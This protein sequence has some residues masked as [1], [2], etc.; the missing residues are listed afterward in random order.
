M[1]LRRAIKNTT[2]GVDRCLWSANR[3]LRVE[4]FLDQSSLGG[5]RQ[6]LAG[7]SVLIRTAD[8][9]TTAAALI[10]LDGIASRILICP[11]DVKSEHLSNLAALAGVEAVV[12]TADAPCAVGAKIETVVW[13][14]TPSPA[15]ESET[16][17]LET[18]WLLLTSGTTGAPKIVR[19]SFASLTGLIKPIAESGLPAVWSTFYDIRR[20]GGL[21][22]FLRAIVGGGSLVL[23]DPQ[24][25]VSDFL[26]RLAG[27]GVTHMSGTPSHWRR[28]L[29]NPKIRVFNPSYIRM[30]GEIADQKII[31]NLR[32]AF[33]NA[34]IAHAYASTEAGVVFS[35]NDEL[36]G[37]PVSMIGQSGRATLVKIIDDTLRIKSPFTAADYVGRD[38]PR[39]R[40]R[41]GF[42]DSGDLVER[43]RDRYYFIG[44]RGGIINVGGLKV[45]PEEIES[46]LN[47]HYAV[48]MSLVK[49]RMNPITGS[50]VVADIVLK[51]CE[52]GADQTELRTEILRAC[53]DVLPS[54]KVPAMIRFVPE[55][56]L[57]ASGKLIR[58]NA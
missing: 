11:P 56:N 51:A 9:L 43:R 48:H 36:A 18:E 4:N 25:A 53:R 39:L 23:S 44:R 33:P 41:E 47:R 35:V 15:H 24:E 50:I 49:S 52:T 38:A 6:A 27:H 8:Q 5:Q 17:E 7:K 32:E 29:M 37:F 40:D 30:P 31:D 14:N 3:S 34:K 46:V 42:V 19:H 28:A 57:A 16:A 2:T 58:A 10:E 13:Q 1:S 12:T 20:Y 21:Q 54:Y 45:H 22:I 26:V 55:L